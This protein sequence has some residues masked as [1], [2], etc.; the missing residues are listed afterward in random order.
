MKTDEEECT[1]P[2]EKKRKQD[3]NLEKP[4]KKKAKM[5]LVEN[6]ELMDLD[7]TSENSSQSIGK[8]VC[9]FLF[10]LLH[11]ITWFHPLSRHWNILIR[12]ASF[13]YRCLITFLA[14]FSTIVHFYC[15]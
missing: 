7:F 12:V 3:E 8:E 5:M 11:S 4:V 1:V 2:P 13:D 10:Y 9:L 14:S 6:K 15:T